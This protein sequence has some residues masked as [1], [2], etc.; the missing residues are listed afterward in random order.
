MVAWFRVHG[1][2]LAAG[3]AILTVATVT[4]IVSYSHIHRLTLVLHQP[5]MVAALMPF[6]V[7]G[8][9]VAGSVVLLQGSLLGW[10]GVGPGAAISLFANV[11]SGIGFGWLAAA[12][13]GVPAVAFALS[14][15]ILERWLKGQAATQTPVPG[16]AR[17]TRVATARAA[18]PGPDPAPVPPPTRRQNRTHVLSL[19]P[20]RLSPA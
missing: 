10:A 11:E 6:G 9:I 7:D 18:H 20:R 14:T 15:F 19:S 13:A 5:P 4:G 8:L 1:P 17:K 3:L 16:S 12:W 2:R